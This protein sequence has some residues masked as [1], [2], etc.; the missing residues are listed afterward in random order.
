[1]LQGMRLLDTNIER[2]SLDDHRFSFDPISAPQLANEYSGH[3]YKLLA[4][5]LSKS[6][7]SIPIFS[8]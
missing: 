8:K 4:I 6:V 1:M 3:A 5:F 2:K 7:E